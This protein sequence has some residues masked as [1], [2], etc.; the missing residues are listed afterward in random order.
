MARSRYYEIRKSQDDRNAHAKHEKLLL[1]A[2]HEEV[3]RDP[4]EIDE[5]EET[6]RRIF[7]L[8]RGIR[9]EVALTPETAHSGPLS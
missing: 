9:F 2:S 4:I 7:V 6:I 5:A 1:A 3:D 8:D